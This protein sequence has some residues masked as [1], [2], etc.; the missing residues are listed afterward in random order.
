MPTKPSQPA[1]KRPQADDLN[2][3]TSVAKA[4]S[5]LDCFR[6][7]DEPMGVTE[8]AR[9]TGLPKSTAFR[10]LSHLEEMGYVERH[11]KQYRPGWLLFELGTGFDAVRGLRGAALPHMA[12]LF[13]LTRQSVHLGALQQD[14]IIHVARIRGHTSARSPIRYG[15]RAPAT[16]SAMGKVLLAHRPGAEITELLGA[17]LP[18][19]TRYSITVPAVLLDQLQQAR[20][21]GYALEQEETGIGLVSVAVPISYNGRDVAAV[22]LA[23]KAESF[24]PQAHIEALRRTSALITQSLAALR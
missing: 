22:A 17:P 18:K 3:A 9:R 2:P 24:K 5:L 20:E 13:A 15:G 19:L 21:R 6:R 11:G 14:E 4:L 16:C 8:L 7:Q 10:L 1:R 23:G 12:D